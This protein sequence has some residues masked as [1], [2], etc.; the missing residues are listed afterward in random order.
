MIMKPSRGNAEEAF[1]GQNQCGFI[2]A[3]IYFVYHVLLTEMTTS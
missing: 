1:R 3:L 2:F